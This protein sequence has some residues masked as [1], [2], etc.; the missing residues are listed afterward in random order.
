MR[1]AVVI[2]PGSNREHDMLDALERTTGKK[3]LRGLHGDSELP[4]LDLIVIP[5]GF[6]Y[7]DY[8]R[9]GA[10]AA[11][12]PI[13]REVKARAAGGTPILGVCNGFQILCE[14][15]LLPGVLLANETL[16]FHCF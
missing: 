5:G 14:A 8:L 2:F 13:M 10:M 9:C 4:K 12:S 11:H 1:A 7:G 15:G 6:S 16:K 3:P